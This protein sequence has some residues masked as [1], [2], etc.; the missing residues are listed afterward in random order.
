M[1]PHAQSVTLDPCSNLRGALG[2]AN[3][4]VYVQAG[5]GFVSMTGEVSA[6]PRQPLE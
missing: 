5:Y 6:H 1:V 4:R 3:V 2:W